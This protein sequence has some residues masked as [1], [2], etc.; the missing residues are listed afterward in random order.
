MKLTKFRGIDHGRSKFRE[1][2]SK[3][4]KIALPEGITMKKI[5]K[6]I[7]QK[8]EDAQQETNTNQPTDEESKKKQEPLLTAFGEVVYQRSGQKDFISKQ[9]SFM[10]EQKDEVLE[11]NLLDVKNLLKFSTSSQAANGK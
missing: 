8:E 4:E 5:F 6:I 1:E 3:I 11:E 10:H 7:N 9:K 2:A